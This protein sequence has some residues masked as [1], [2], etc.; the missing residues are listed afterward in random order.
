MKLTNFIM[1]RAYG[2][3]HRELECYE[4]ERSDYGIGRTFEDII[5]EY[6]RLIARLTMSDKEFR[7]SVRGVYYY[8]EEVD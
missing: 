7:D 1:I 2:A 3:I 6:I 4:L 5:N 8:W